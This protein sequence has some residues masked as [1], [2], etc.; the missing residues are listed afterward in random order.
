MTSQTFFFFSFRAC[1]QLGDDPSD[2]EDFSGLGGKARGFPSP[3][4]LQDLERWTADSFWLDLL[5]AG[6]PSS[7]ERFRGRSLAWDTSPG[8]D[9][10]EGQVGGLPRAR[11]P[12]D[13][14]SDSSFHWRSGHH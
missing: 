12:P 8:V 5:S 10:S 4:T 2:P 3:G 11:P 7:A 6:S 13:S 14:G 1:S 9:T